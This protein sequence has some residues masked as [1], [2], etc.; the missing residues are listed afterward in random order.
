MRKQTTRNS[1][2]W[3]LMLAVFAAPIFLGSCNDD[4]DDNGNGTSNQ[5]NQGNNNT[6]V[7]DSGTFNAK[8]SGDISHEFKGKAFY[9]DTSLLTDTGSSAYKPEEDAALTFSLQTK[10]SNKDSSSITAIIL[11]NEDNSRVGKGTYNTKGQLV[12][13]NDILTGSSVIANTIKA[14]STISSIGGGSVEIT[15]RSG[16][17]V[18]GTFNDVKMVAISFGTGSTDTVSLNGSFAAREADL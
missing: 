6:N 7:P 1:I 5:N 10:E 17:I 3:M 9:N 16:N 14:E 15:S 8:F 2:V 13:E 12:L 11:K 18:K 4:D